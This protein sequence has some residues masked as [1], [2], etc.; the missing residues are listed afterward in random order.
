[1]KRGCRGGK[2]VEEGPI[3][4]IYVEIRLDTAM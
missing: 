3:A 4:I 1:M 2:G